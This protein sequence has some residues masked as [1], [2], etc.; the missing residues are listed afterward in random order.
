MPG[1]AAVEDG[2]C[3]SGGDSRL[4]TF[5]PGG[6]E[7]DADALDALSD[8]PAEWTE[9]CEDVRGDTRPFCCENLAAYSAPVEDSILLTSLAHRRPQLLHRS[10]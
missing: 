8:A 1:V 4:T 7:G 9:C 3:I 10:R 2:S 5:P 6:Y